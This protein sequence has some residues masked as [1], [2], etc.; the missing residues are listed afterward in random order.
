MHGKSLQAPL[1]LNITH[2]IVLVLGSK[3]IPVSFCRQQ[4][5]SALSRPSLSRSF[6]VATARSRDTGHRGYSSPTNRARKTPS[7]HVHTYNYVHVLN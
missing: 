4:I 6:A 3:V 1:S 5:G 7:L 2:V